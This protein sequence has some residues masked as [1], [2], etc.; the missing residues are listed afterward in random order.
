MWQVSLMILASYLTSLSC[1]K[2]LVDLR[3]AFL[4]RVLPEGALH[5]VAVLLVPDVAW[6]HTCGLSPTAPVLASC[7]VSFSDAV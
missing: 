1:V 4:A 5:P 2:R 7:L 3:L 6:V